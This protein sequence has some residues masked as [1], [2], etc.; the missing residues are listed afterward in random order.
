MSKTNKL[1]LL[2]VMR[3]GGYCFQLCEE[4]LASVGFHS[5]CLSVPC[6]LLVPH[7]LRTNRNVDE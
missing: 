4:R 3:P 6:L 1:T 2:P 5:Q 7:L